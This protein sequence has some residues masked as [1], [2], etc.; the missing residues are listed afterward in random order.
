MVYQTRWRENYYPIYVDDAVY[1][2]IVKG[3]IEAGGRKV[4]V[5]TTK[6]GLSRLEKTLEEVYNEKVKLSSYDIVKVKIKLDALVKRDLIKKEENKSATY[7]YYYKNSLLGSIVNKCLKKYKDIN[8]N[9]N[10]KEAVG[11]VEN[12]ILKNL[13]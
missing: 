2:L 4:N 1:A 8:G 12:Y 3:Y 7:Y 13:V 11:C 10:I 6:N 5:F 9:Y